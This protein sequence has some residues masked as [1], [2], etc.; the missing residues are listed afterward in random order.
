MSIRFCQL[1]LVGA[2]LLSLI[3][4]V[5]AH[6]REVDYEHFMEIVRKEFIGC[7]M[8]EL[9]ILDLSFKIIAT[10]CFGLY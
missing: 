3:A 8:V 10:T 4:V 1:S 9:F 7:Q 5:P 6:G 2:V